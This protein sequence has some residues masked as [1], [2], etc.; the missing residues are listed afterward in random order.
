MEKVYIIRYEDFDDYNGNYSGISYVF[1]NEKQAKNMLQTIYKD[2]LRDLL[3]QYTDDF[4]DEEID[5]NEYEIRAINNDIEI[6]QNEYSIQF[7]MGGGDRIIKYILE[8]TE[9]QKTE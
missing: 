5:E 8:E 6:K 7:T 4:D 2:E 9:I 3:Y 1:A